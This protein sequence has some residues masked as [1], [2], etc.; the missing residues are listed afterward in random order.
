[1]HALPLT[2]TGTAAGGRMAIP[3]LAN[4]LFTRV[5][6]KKPAPKRTAMRMMMA[7]ALLL[8]PV[9]IISSHFVLEALKWCAIIEL[10]A[11]CF[12]FYYYEIVKFD[13]VSVCALCV[14]MWL[15]PF[16]LFF[17][18]YGEKYYS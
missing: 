16:I 3:T 6:S 13:G 5:Y 2:L 18:I 7:P 1:V 15:L 14:M 11:F 4:P 9:L 12:G 10:A 8:V 17:F